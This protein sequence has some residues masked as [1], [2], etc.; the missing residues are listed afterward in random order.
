MTVMKLTSFE[1]TRYKGV[2]MFEIFPFNTDYKFSKTKGFFRDKELIP[3]ADGNFEVFV[4]NKIFK[5]HSTW[6]YLVSVYAP[7]CSF[8]TC[9]K[10]VYFVNTKSKVLKVNCGALMFFRHPVKVKDEFYMVPGF[11]DYVIS[12]KGVVRSLKTDRILKIHNA[13]YPC[14]SIYD[15]DKKRY[16]DVT[17]HLLLARTFIRNEHPETKIYVNHKNGIKLD[18]SL[19]NLEWVSTRENNVH[20]INEGLRPDN[21]PCKVKNVL[22][23]EIQK[24]NTKRE[25]WDYCKQMNPKSKPFVCLNDGVLLRGLFEFKLVDDEKPWSI[26][27]K[28]LETFSFKSEDGY[29]ALNRKTGEVFLSSTMK[30]LADKIGL[31]LGVVRRLIHLGPTFSNNG[32]SVRA[33]SNESW[34]VESDTVKTRLPVPVVLKNTEIG[35]EIRFDNQADAY[36]FLGIDKR[37]FKNYIREKKSVK[38]WNIT[39]PVS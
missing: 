36:R 17:I 16:R 18:F 11:C 33:K 19:S 15:R 13:P 2:G 6:L 26:T 35:E 8:E 29:E 21:L 39:C 4:D 30:C 1:C 24:F 34:P 20:A 12:K 22:T 14:V 27:P 31:S 25:A 5:I 23:G 38:G 7:C 28:D 32:F 9:L 10:E 3:D 37:T